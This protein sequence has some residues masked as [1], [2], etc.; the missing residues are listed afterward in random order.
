MNALSV[1]ERWD[2][3]LRAGDWEL[4]R[5]LLTDDATYPAPEADAEYRVDCAS[6]YEIIEL[7]TKFKG[8]NPDVE[9]VEWAEPGNRV[10]ARLRQ[11]AWGPEAEW[12]QVLTVR[13]SGSPSL[14][15]MGQR[16]PQRPPSVAA[17]K[18]TRVR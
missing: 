1:V 16:H 10:L 2:S 6:D 7:M 15:T 8:V 18:G 11:P 17:G 4:G 13:G 12:N 9:V 5:S 14:S 3:S